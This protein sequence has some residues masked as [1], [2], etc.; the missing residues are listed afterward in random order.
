MTGLSSEEWSMDLEI[1]RCGVKAQTLHMLAVGPQAKHISET[2][3]SSVRY[4][5]YGYGNDKVS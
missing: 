5:P 2:V 3:H 1:S 4:L